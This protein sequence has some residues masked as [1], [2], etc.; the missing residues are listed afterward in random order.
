M[1][2][3]LIV[4]KPEGLTSADVVRL[5]KRATRVK[6]GHLGTLDP[7]A[8]GVLPLCLGDG[9]KI[10]QFLSVADKRYTG[11]IQLGIQTDTGDR[12][13][14]VVRDAA[15]PTANTADLESLARR[16]CGDQLQTPPMYS[17]IKRD[18][19]PLYKLARKGHEVDRAPRAIMIYALQIRPVGAARLEFEV[20]CSKGTY[21]RVLAQDIGEALGT[22]AHL[23]ALRRTAFGSFD[24]LHATTVEDLKAGNVTGVLNL[25][26]ALGHLPE[27]FIDADTVERTRCGQPA[28]VR[29]L[30][31]PAD[32][33]TA[34]LIGPSGELVAVVTAGENGAW[35]LVRV[36]GGR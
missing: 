28:A 6:V 1:D 25:R 20:H 31:G 9:T 16:F 14:R 12:T 35:R 10:A 34:K 33:E 2:G 13:G 5:A 4:D 17:A 30:S 19:V 8:T 32:A 18:G 22:V 23:A 11:V 29:D 26:A 27:I 3:I 15:V 7:F 21:V 24:L 36:F